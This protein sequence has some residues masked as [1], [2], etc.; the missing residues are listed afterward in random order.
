[1]Q[2][3]MQ[4]FGR[5]WADW[6]TSQLKALQSKRTKLIRAKPPPSILATH[7]SRVETQI[8][9]IQ[10][11]LVD[12]VALKAKIRWREKGEVS[13]GYLKRTA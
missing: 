2:H 4:R 1:I 6:R 12:N 8:A 3:L 9:A 7:L 10:Q 5:K 13:A 11:E